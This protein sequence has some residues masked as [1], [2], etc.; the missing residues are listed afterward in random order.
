MYLLDDDSTFVNAEFSLDIIE[1]MQCIVV[2]SSGGASSVQGRSRRNPDYNKLIKVILTRLVKLQIKITKIILDS[3]KV[4]NIPMDERIARLRVNYPIDLS[5]V[6]IDDFRKM[7]GRT[8]ALMHR[9]P[10]ATRS[11]N[12]QKRI[13]ICLDKP[14][15]P[16][17]ILA[18]SSDI[19]TVENVEDEIF[20]HKETEREYLRTARLGQGNFRKELLKKHL[21]KCPITG[22]TNSD[23]LIASHIKPWNVCTNLERLDPHNGILLSPIIDRLFDKG[24]IT[25]S[26]EGTILVSPKLSPSDTKLCNIGAANTLPLSEKNKQYLT[27]HRQIQFK[28]N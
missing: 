24:L 1:A 21:S 13:R 9:T 25:F 7:L 16:A 26:N 28:K 5:S 18:A 11:G 23:L 10:N 14:I 4:A 22:I 8:I 17:Q 20:S 12:A 3:Q 27:Y 15:T 19:S 6:N 2:E